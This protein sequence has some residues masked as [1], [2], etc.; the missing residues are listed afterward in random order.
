[1]TRSAEIQD[2]TVLSNRSAAAAAKEPELIDCCD[3]ATQRGGEVL[4]MCES[5]LAR[6]H[7]LLKTNARRAVRLDLKGTSQVAS[8]NR[9]G[10]RKKTRKLGERPHTGHPRRHDH[11]A[12]LATGPP[13]WV[14]RMDPLLRT[15]AISGTVMKDR[16]ASCVL[17][18]SRQTKVAA[19]PNCRRAC[20]CVGEL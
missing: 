10:G 20:C 7:T 19:L 18:R 5:V 6:G 11:N 3:A 16:A 1:M 14:W 4:E 15:A 13:E 9:L 12:F 17:A 8:S 2:R